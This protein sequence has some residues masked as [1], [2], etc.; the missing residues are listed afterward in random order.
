MGIAKAFISFT[1]LLNWSCQ[2]RS[3]YQPCE[4]TQSL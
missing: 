4:W 2:R 3:I 1:A